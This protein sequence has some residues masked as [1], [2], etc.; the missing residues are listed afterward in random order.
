MTASADVHCGHQHIRLLGIDA[1]EIEPRARRRPGLQAEP[2]PGAAVRPCRYQ[3]VTVDRH[4][5]TI[6]GV[7]AGNVNLSCRQPGRGQGQAIYTAKWE[8]ARSSR[9]PAAY[10]GRRRREPM[11]PQTR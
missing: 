2:R 11:R 8:M 5:L 7:G 9:A 3:P 10:S 6:A 4:G 1:P